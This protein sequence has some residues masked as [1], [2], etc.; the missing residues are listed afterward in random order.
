MMVFVDLTLH[1]FWLS[2]SNRCTNERSLRKVTTFF[3]PFSFLLSSSL[4]AELYHIFEM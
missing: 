1:H 2:S 4:R 3:P